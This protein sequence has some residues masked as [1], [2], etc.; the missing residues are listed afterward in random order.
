MIGFM[1]NLQ[2][3]FQS[4]SIRLTLALPEVGFTQVVVFGRS[5]LTLIH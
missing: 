1:L 4:L 2:I 5:E 3:N